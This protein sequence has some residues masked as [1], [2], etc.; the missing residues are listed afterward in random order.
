M[1]YRGQC[2]CGSTHF[3]VKGEP[4][5]TQYCHCNKCRLVAGH[6]ENPADKIGYGFTAAYLTE[7]FK[8]TQGQDAL[9]AIV[10]NN[11]RLYLC[12]QCGTLIYGISEDPHK[13]GGIGINMNNFQ[14]VEGI[15]ASFKPVRH[16]WYQDRIINVSDALPKFKNAPKEQ[17][18]TG[19]LY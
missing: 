18:G 9:T 11:A 19:E 5:F 6:S 7:N 15:P 12:P 4:L 10:R 3:E 13:Q 8:I 1:N 2:L 17:F 16:I 14:F